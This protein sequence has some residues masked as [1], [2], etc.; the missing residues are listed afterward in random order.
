VRAWL[1]AN[2]VAVLNIAGPRE[3]KR[4]GI[5]QRARDFLVQLADA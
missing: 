2:R 4:P 3:S 5:Y 1:Q